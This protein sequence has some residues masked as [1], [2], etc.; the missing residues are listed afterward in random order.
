MYNILETAYGKPI[1]ENLLGVPN[2]LWENQRIAIRQFTF[3]DSEIDDFVTY[4]FK[5]I[6]DHQ[7]RQDEKRLW[8]KGAED[9]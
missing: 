2:Y 4:E 5:P 1:R 3:T 6:F 8:E 7:M 9:L